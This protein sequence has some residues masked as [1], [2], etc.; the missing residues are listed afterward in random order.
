MTLSSVQF[1]TV[2][3]QIPKLHCSMNILIKEGEE[4][5]MNTL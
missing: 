1:I 4:K 3:L 5:K 2:H